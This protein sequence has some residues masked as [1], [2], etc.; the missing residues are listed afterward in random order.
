MVRLQRKRCSVAVS[1]ALV[2]MV[3][4]VASA[5]VPK[6]AA[7]A[8][9]KQSPVLEAF[10]ESG[11]MPHIIGFRDVPAVTFKT[12]L[13]ASS[14]PLRGKKALDL[15]ASVA[16]Y[17]ET[18]EARQKALE[19]R[20]KS[21]A[22]RSFEVTHRM[23]HAFNGIVA[24]LSPAEAAALA[25][26]PAVTLVEP[27]K[28]FALDDDTGPGVIGAP[29]VWSSGTGIHR[30]AFM[31]RERTGVSL[32]NR[33]ALGEG[34]LV[35]IIDT[36]INL[37][38]PSFAEVDPLSGFEF[39]NPL[40][41]GNYLGQC[42]P[43][44]VDAGRCND[45]LIGGHDFVFSAVC[46][47]NAPATDPCRPGGTFR[48]EASFGD[49]DG[50]GSHVAGTSA[51]NSRF[52]SFRGN[53][54][55]ISGIAP[56]AHVVG[57]D[58]CYT[59]VATGQGLCPNVSTLASINQAVIDGVD[60]INY[61]IGGGAQPWSEAI[62]LAFL[63]AADAGIFVAASAGNSGPGPSTNGHN[64]PWVTTVAAAQSGRD[65]F[66]FTLNTS[67]AN[68]PASLQRVVLR[69]G[70]GG[71]ELSATVPSLP[72]R[73]GPGF[74]GTSDGCTASGAFPAGFFANRIALVRRG[75]CT[76]IE[77]A[78]NAAAAGARAVILVNNAAGILT[79][80]VPGATVPV[81]GMPQ[82][83]GVALQGL[84]ATDPTLTASIPFPATRITNTV[85]QLA[86]F[87][88]RGP[89]PFSLLK[90]NITGHGV[91]I[92]EP[93]ACPDPAQWAT[94]AC[95]N[96]AGLMSGTSMSA[97]QI[98]GAAALLRQL[99]PD[100]SPAEVQSAL[101]MT[102]T[103]TVRLEDG[104]TPAHPFAAGAGRVQVDRAA[105]AGLVL[106]EQRADY[107][108]ANP[109]IGGD[110]AGLN[111][112]G[113][114]NRGCGPTTCT[115]TRTFRSTRG[116]FQTFSASLSGVTGSISTPVFTVA[117]FG[118]ATVTVTVNTAGQ[119]ADGSFRFGALTLTSTGNDHASRSPDLRLPVAVAVRAPE[120]TLS[121][122]TIAISAPANTSRSASFSVWSNSNP[123]EFSVST[124]GT[125]TGAVVSQSRL[126]A[127]SGFATGFFTDFGI[128]LYAGDDF[129][130][131]ASS[132]IAR[133]S[134]DLFNVG[135]LATP[136]T[137]V[138]WSIF[139]DAGGVPAGNPETSPGAAVWRFSSPL[140]GPGV[141]LVGGVLRLDLAAAGQNVTLPPGRYWLVPQINTTFANRYAWFV[142]NEGNG[143]PPRLIQPSLA[144]PGNTWNVPPNPPAGMAFGIIGTVGC[145]APWIGGVAPA[146]GRGLAGAPAT[147]GFTVN[148]QGLAPGNYTGFV[149]VNSNDP[150]RPQAS[151]RV[152]LTVTP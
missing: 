121:T 69:A 141:S 144:P 100:W 53:V 140:S 41:P 124:T 78:N 145:G 16:Q 57:Y 15:E 91:N 101:M 76:F 112:A 14:P 116:T 29:T 151:V 54:V 47:P 90:P 125:G 95:I 21:V 106:D 49:N 13:K 135:A 6:L 89:A 40:G 9:V 33:R 107:L 120:L 109:G 64:Q 28:E 62:S 142:S 55:E 132:R 128:G 58:A 18:L 96:A 130:V 56:R 143:T 129:V 67:G 31:T 152:N 26:D 70:S 68:V 123:V 17:A 102:A 110:P 71:V 113:L 149:C 25:R 59:L 92:L 1:A 34:V 75:G 61:S 99:F 81:F 11:R 111:L 39:S 114:V 97:P 133:I 105:R 60:V 86:A 127:T 84:A 8:V 85:D 3:G 24:T 138:Q 52:V 104:V 118:T 22:G 23:Q 43:G 51:G 103:Q 94:P 79:P 19:T 46:T 7:E 4:T 98:A 115:F 38:S 148:T 74:A 93:V 77:K 87:S 35:G 134:T 10:A 5:A 83:E 126:G 137:V 80:S 66:E 119:P 88:S 65:G 37:R 117:P 27:Y 50:H 44:G 2:A 63:A 131:P 150:A 48:E 136:A 72:L 147:V 32:F 82:A 139:P 45:K 73:A 122:E 42:R 36:G 12:Q 108:A 20:L 30:A 146:S